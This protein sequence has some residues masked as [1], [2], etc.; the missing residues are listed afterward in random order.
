MAD[1]QINVGVG[2][3]DE[4]SSKMKTIG[5]NVK[6]AFDKI[7]LA[8]GVG[9]AAVTGFGLKA[10]SDF[11]DA[12]EHIANLSAQT[13]ISALS[14]SGMKVAADEMGLSL[15]QV[16]G[17]TKKMQL[18]IAAFGDDTKKANAALKPLGLT[19][20]DIK[21]LKPEEQLFK[22][23]DA[24]AKIKD[25]TER[26]AAAV[27]T[28]G[29][30]GADLIPFFQDGNANL[31]DFVKHAKDMGLAFD[32]ISAN[33][34][35]AL[36]TAFDNLH[37]SIAGATQQVAVALAPAITNLVNQITPWL[38]KLSQWMSANPE[39]TLQIGMWTAAILAGIAVLGPLAT[40][41][42]TVGAAMTFLAANP[43]VA[44]IAALVALG[45][46]IAYII[47]HWNEF[48]TTV[49]AVWNFVSGFIVKV[50]GDIWKTITTWFGN[51]TKDW[52][53][54]WEGISTSAQGIWDTIVAEITGFITGIGNVIK[55]GVD[56]ITSAWSGLWSGLLST[57]SG[58]IGTIKG[59]VDGLISSIASAISSIGNLGKTSGGA[60]GVAANWRGGSTAT[61][62]ASGGAFS[63]G[64]KLRVG[65]QGP[66]EV[67]FGQS[68][69]VTPNNQLGG[70]GIIINI[71][72]NTLLDSQAA[73]KMGDLI[74]QRLRLQRKLA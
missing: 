30:S 65:E 60:A 1:N 70:G 14:L 23:G 4:I 24:I 58:I 56:G 43:I 8:A 2:L 44:V 72:G 22:M 47:T 7:S 42:G 59:F 61:P 62:K 48:L 19:F 27:K 16:T 18:N 54:G 64:Q 33:K 52:Q 31:S 26:T 51:L 20:A 17:A 11:A 46:G 25:P 66:E 73:M 40:V 34:A 35:A 68:G 53:A 21:N 28:F 55:G 45:L 37:S 10:A 9:L 74:I 15:E 29:K 49:Q 39:L 3:K 69:F 13:G 50:A 71:S 67:T 38:E 5:E 63:A 6:G 41:I 12:G 57:A 36:D 32:D